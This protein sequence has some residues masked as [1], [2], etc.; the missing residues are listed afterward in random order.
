MCAIY[1]TADSCTYD[2]HS[3][4]RK[5]RTTHNTE[6]LKQRIETFEALFARL[7]NC[8]SE[9]LAD[10]VRSLRDEESCSPS[11]G[12]ASDTNVK[13]EDSE[14]VQQVDDLQLDE[15]GEVHYYGASSNLPIIGHTATGQGAASGIM[16]APDHE[17]A[18]KFFDPVI[19]EALLDLYW[20]WQHPYFQVLDRRL[21]LRDRAQAAREGFPPTK[22]KFYSE[23]LLCAI[24]A[25]TSHLYPEANLRIH[26]NDPRSAGNVYYERAR[27][28]MDSESL[29]P[30]LCT[31]QGCLILSS[32]EAGLGRQSRGWLYSGMAFRLALDLG[33]HVS[34]TFSTL[35][36]NHISLL[37]GQL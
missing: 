36:Q 6:V 35:L 21:F 17:Q 29:R 8:P 37:S 2:K 32:R 28:L 18:E 19:V 20:S 1:K 11:T 3:D 9:D 31:I 7:K 27:Q 13:T 26:P 34:S 23:F 5:L 22:R 25:L 4:R 30:G 14:L 16:N 10:F 15:D 12:S 24:L 33:L